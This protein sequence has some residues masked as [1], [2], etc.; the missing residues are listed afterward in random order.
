[1]ILV[2]DLGWQ[3]LGPASQVAPDGKHAH[4]RTP[5]VDRLAREGTLFTQAYA[6][7]PVCTPTRVSLL[8]G[9]MPA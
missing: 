2:D 6:A 5:N 3:D 1:M 4:F 8:T 9:Q 7:A